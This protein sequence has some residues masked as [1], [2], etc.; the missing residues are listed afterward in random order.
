MFSLG[1]VGVNVFSV[2][3]VLMFLDEFLDCLKLIMS[4]LC[5]FRYVGVSVI[6]FVD[7]I[8]CRL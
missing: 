2:F 8:V 1:V 3:K 4:G 6:K 5:F 7:V